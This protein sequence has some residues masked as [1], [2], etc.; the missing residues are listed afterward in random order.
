M[1]S[2]ERD[3]EKFLESG[4]FQ[5]YLEECDLWREMALAEQQGCLKSGNTT[6]AT[7]LSGVIES[8]AEFKQRMFEALLATSREDSEDGKDDDNG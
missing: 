5:D 2:T 1:R 4:L 3:V 6:M 7:H 8:I